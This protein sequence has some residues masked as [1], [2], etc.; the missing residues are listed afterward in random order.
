MVFQREDFFSLLFLRVLFRVLEEERERK[1]RFIEKK[2][3]KLLFVVIDTTTPSTAITSGTYYF[4]SNRPTCVSV[5]HMNKGFSTVITLVSS[6]SN[7]LNCFGGLNIRAC[8]ME[9]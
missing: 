7:F 9:S 4:F 6:A 1:R 2:G 5:V 3:C 8:E